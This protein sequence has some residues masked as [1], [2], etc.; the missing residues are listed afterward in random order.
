MPATWLSLEVPTPLVLTQVNQTKVKTYGKQP[1]EK[2]GK[3]SV[4]QKIYL[5]HTQSNISVVSDHIYHDISSS[6]PQ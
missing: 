4:S 5:H 1:V 2:P 6:S 3:K